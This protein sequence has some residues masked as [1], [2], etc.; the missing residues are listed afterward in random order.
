MSMKPIWS[1]RTDRQRVTDG[2]TDVTKLIRRCA[3]KSL[4]RPGSKQTTANKL[5]IYSTHFPRR[6]VHFLPRCSNFCKPLKNKKIRKLSVQPGLRGSNDLRVGQKIATFQLFSFSPE[7][8]GSPT[9]P[10]PENRVGDQDTGS[11]RRPV[12]Y[13]LQVP[14]E[15]GHCRATTRPPS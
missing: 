6:S 11:P 4:A 5:G 1:K 10:D 2:L 9:G 12:S 8:V 7:K 14:G 3:E 15:Q 13:G